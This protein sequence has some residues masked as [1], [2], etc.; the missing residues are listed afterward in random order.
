MESLAEGL[1]CY[2]LL[3]SPDVMSDIQHHPSSTAASPAERRGPLLG[4]R[5][6]EF[7]SIGPGPHC[8]MLLADMGAEVV[9]IDRPE[10]YGWTNPVME[11]GRRVVTVEIRTDAGRE[12]CSSA[13]SSADVLI[14]GLR[15]GVMERLGLGPEILLKQNPRLI[16]ARMTGWG[17]EGP[18]ANTAGHDIRIGARLLRA[19]D[20]THR[21]APG[22]SGKSTRP[23]DMGTPHD[24][25]CRH[26]RDSHDGRVART[27]IGHRRVRH[28][29]PRPR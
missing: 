16:Y 17:Q 27:P 21:R 26:L 10:G 4:L 25:T 1:E 13:A 5:V 29:S 11:R 3:D 28:T 2:V 9:R 15:P 14:E 22:I 18:L 8:A 20:R 19:T 12:Y 23:I 6:L 7:A 24:R